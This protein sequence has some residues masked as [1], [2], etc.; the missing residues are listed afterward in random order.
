MRYRRAT[1]AGGRFFFTVNLADRES[2]LLVQHV[3][4][5]RDIVRKVRDKHP[6]T[7]TAMVVLPEHLHA[8]WT[9]PPGDSDYPIRWSLIKAGFSR[10]MAPDKSTSPSRALKRERTI[11]QRRYWE[12]QI[13]NEEDLAH[14][15]DYIHYNPV[16]HG[17]ADS[18]VA[19]HHSSIHQYI[20]RGELAAD[21]GVAFEEKTRRSGER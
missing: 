16:K 13:R 18:P 21:W 19:W 6:F 7:I 2:D 8:I 1:A 4:I 5:L 14:H 3:D 17:W 20:A 11:W 15:V 9:L 10:R 12:H